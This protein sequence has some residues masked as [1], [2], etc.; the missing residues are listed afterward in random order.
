MGPQAF[1]WWRVQG[2][3]EKCQ[4]RSSTLIH[5]SQAG[6]SSAC[7]FKVQHRLVLNFTSCFLGL[8]YCI[9]PACYSSCCEYKKFPTDVCEKEKVFFTWIAVP[10]ILYFWWVKGTSIVFICVSV[11]MRETLANR[12]VMHLCR[13]QLQCKCWVSCGAKQ[14]HKLTPGGWNFLTTEHIKR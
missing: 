12:Q 2:A 9:T 13:Q 14:S 8:L 6:T 7:K 4:V 3:V 5:P 10:V 11:F 1:S